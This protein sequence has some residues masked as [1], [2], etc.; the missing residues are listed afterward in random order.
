MYFCDRKFKILGKRA[1][2]KFRGFCLF[3]FC[4]AVEILYFGLLEIA[5]PWKEKKK[6][7]GEIKGH[8]L[9]C[10]FLQIK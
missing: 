10:P 4:Q 3:V 8:L 9:Q 1:Y 7:V 5:N 2:Q 6:E